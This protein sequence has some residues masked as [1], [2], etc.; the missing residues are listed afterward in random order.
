[1]LG[2]RRVGTG[3]CG[4]LSSGAFPTPGDPESLLSESALRGLPGKE[5]ESGRVAQNGSDGPLLSGVAGR[6]AL[7]LFELARDENKVDDV[8]RNL[9]AFDALFQGNADLQK[10]VK[11]PAYTAEAQTAAIS[12]V[13]DKAGISGLA[14]N[15]IKLAA[16]KRRLFA[17]PDMI[18]AYREKVRESKG[19]VRADVRVAE[20]PSDAL[21]SEI[22]SALKEVAGSDVDLHLQVDP[23]LIG[24]MVVK[25]GSRMIDASL[26]TKLNGIRLAMQ[27]AR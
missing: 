22:K 13:L 10:L 15:F 18:R 12:A 6:Y 5:K 2:P 20:K 11:S 7:A 9:D 19:I 26:K 17:V 3:P 1:M 14:A 8:T 16:S 21:V 23:S 4:I 24:G 27:G 25:I